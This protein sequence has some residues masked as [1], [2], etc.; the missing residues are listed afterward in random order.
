MTFKRINLQG[1]ESSDGFVVQI[2]GRFALHYIEGDHVLPIDVEV[3]E[4]VIIHPESIQW[5]NPPFENEPIPDSKKREILANVLA[6]LDFM[7]EPYEL[8]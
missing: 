1:V 7:G 6:A 5:W 2:A 8:A 4:V 3:S